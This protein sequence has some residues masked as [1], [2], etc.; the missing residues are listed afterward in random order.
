MGG[1]GGEEVWGQQAEQSQQQ[2]LASR[3]HGSYLQS[4]PGRSNLSAFSEAL[5]A[6]RLT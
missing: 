6:I 4:F 1:G 2:S 5:Q 3:L